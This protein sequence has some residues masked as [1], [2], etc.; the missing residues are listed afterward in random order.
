MGR[1]LVL[2]AILTVTV[3]Q[4]GTAAQE[5]GETS[6]AAPAA[7]PRPPYLQ[8]GD[9]VELRYR[10][11]RERLERFFESFGARLETGAPDLAGKLREAPPALV[12]YGYG[13]LP[14]LVPDPA[15]KAG[16]WRVTS[17]SYS[18]RR[19]N[20]FID[21]DLGI[22]EKLETRLARTTPASSEDPRPEWTKMVDEYRTLAANQK[23]TVSHIEYNR[24]W[25]GEIARRQAYYDA[26][27]ALH[28]AVL[29]RQAFLDT[30]EAGDSTLEP[31]LRA[32]ADSLSSRI[33]DVTHRASPPEFLRVEHPSPHRWIVRVPVY[34][35][36]EDR[37][38]VDAFQS[39]VENVWR[40]RDGDDEFS[41]ALE[42]RRVPVIQIYPDGT[43]PARGEHIDMW[44][45]IGRFPPG[46][47]VLT[48]GSNFT[49]VL[50][51]SIDVGPHD[52]APNVLAHEFGHMLGFPDAY[53][54]G[55]R[56]RGS[57]GFEVL[58]VVIDRDDIMSEPGY[59]R[60]SRRLFERLLD[61]TRGRAP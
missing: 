19:T 60:A 5:R 15:K 61:A 14:K 24:L 51:R 56:D 39:A 36:I 49:Y 17:V 44:G 8:R 58:E 52:L 42:I 55:Y 50:N 4:L 21:R 40:V 1:A 27:T 20:G 6:G 43:R 34:T 32:R 22:L 41:V 30:L 57:E 9:E 2:G 3:F 25:Q 29:E 13:I 48:T 18:W 26:Q 31:Y 47:A 46:G 38:F 16:V 59:G 10:G 45:H 23:L 28:D 53:F 11:Y 37:S 7:S 12:P 54:R 33:H 35:D